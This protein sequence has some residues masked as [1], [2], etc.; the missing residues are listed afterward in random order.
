MRTTLLICILAFARTAFAQPDLET[1]E[2]RHEGLFIRLTPGFGA[3][4]TAAKLPDGTDVSM[5]GPAG[6]FGIAI[7]GALT[8]HLILAAD[9]SAT[10]VI[11]PTVKIGDQKTDTS[12]DVSWTSG[13]FGASVAYYVMPLN[14]SISGGAGVFRMALDVPHMDIAR[15]NY[16]GAA[17]LGVAK[18]WW[19]SPRWGLGATLEATAGAVPDDKTK[20]NGWGFFGVDLAFSA[21]YN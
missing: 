1:G 13:Y 21:T 5:Y 7:G 11:G 18:E 10:S 14:L 9:L 3:A 20:D 2:P 8:E 17:K 15:T 6:T 12:N 4:A 16:G 19:V